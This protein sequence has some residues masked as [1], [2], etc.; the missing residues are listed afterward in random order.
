MGG[1]M[2][3]K[4]LKK[5]IKLNWNWNIAERYTPPMANWKFLLERVG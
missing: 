5:F 3:P 2:R 4:N 1:S